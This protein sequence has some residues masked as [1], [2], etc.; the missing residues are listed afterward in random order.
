VDN[1]VQPLQAKAVKMA[2]HKMTSLSQTF[3]GRAD[4][5]RRTLRW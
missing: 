2:G 3:F 4:P 5:A 1:R